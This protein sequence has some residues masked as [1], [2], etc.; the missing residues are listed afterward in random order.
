MSVFD[1][2]KK[3]LQQCRTLWNRT[4]L[5]YQGLAFYMYQLIWET[6]ED[7]NYL[8]ISVT[9][10]HTNLCQA[11][12]N[13]SITIT[14]N[15]RFICV[16]FLAVLSCNSLTLLSLGFSYSISIT[17]RFS[18]KYRQDLFFNNKIL[19]RLSI[20]SFLLYSVQAAVPAKNKHYARS[21]IW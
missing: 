3:F 19:K 6:L 11:K 16:Y 4:H 18:S 17:T 15:L 12:H 13:N 8:S 9:S 20:L 10:G 21:E 14:M 2:H 5:I 7:R 1:S